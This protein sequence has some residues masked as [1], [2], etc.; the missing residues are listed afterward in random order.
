[1]FIVYK[2]TNIKNNKVYIGITSSTM[3]R[4]WQEHINSAMN[5]SDN[6]IFHKAIRRYGKD[7]FVCEVLE[8]N[9]SKEEACSRERYYIEAYD[10]FFS[11]G[12]GY[13][14][15]Y[16]GDHNDHLAG[17]LSYQALV[18][19]EQA[20]YIRTLLTDNSL[21]YNDILKKID[22]PVSE[23]N[24]R[25]ISDINRGRTYK[26]MNSKYPIRPDARKLNKIN[27]LGQKNPAAKLTDEKVQQ[28]VELLSSTKKT[29]LEIGK[30]F[31]VSY[32]TINLI[33]RCKIWNH[34]HN[35]KYNIRQGR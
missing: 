3:K 24:W 23:A 13:N 9:L 30:I 32:N 28:I 33:N 19:D 25:F 27:R 16:G 29:Q 14:M 4:R 35:Y 7:S 6:Y 11:Q 8:K 2:I 5:K 20:Q 12:K 31:G 26:Q 10:S 34:I 15:T 22:L 1:M 17:G 18:S 21:T